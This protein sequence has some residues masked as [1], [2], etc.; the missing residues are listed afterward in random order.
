MR[1]AS[2]E[3]GKQPSLDQWGLYDEC[4]ATV[5]GRAMVAMP[6]KVI[7]IEVRAP[8]GEASAQAETLAERVI[9]AVRKPIAAQGMAMGVGASVGIA[10]CPV[11]A[12][13]SS[14]LLRHAD[15]AMYAAKQ[16]GKSAYRLFDPS[17]TTPSEPSE[18][19]HIGGQT[20]ANRASGNEGHH[21]NP[22]R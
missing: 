7:E 13:E 19:L 14:A 4:S 5:F 22:P 12:A 17:M 1:K 21:G 9:A 3:A 15:I 2:G 10:C 20:A 16:A 6:D 18:Q 11:H 8:L